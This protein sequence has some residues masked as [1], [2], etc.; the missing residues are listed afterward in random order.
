MTE[1]FVNILKPEWY[2]MSREERKRQRGE[3]ETEK[4]PKEEPKEKRIKTEH[5]GTKSASSSR[6]TSSS[7]SSAESLGGVASPTLCGPGSDDGTATTDVTN[8]KKKIVGIGL[9]RYQTSKAIVFH[10]VSTNS[11]SFH[12][13]KTKAR[14]ALSSGVF[15][16]QG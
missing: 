4:E 10:G 5:G 14:T 2:N 9:H 15:E 11:S 16:A 12:R 6:P 1:H 3:K 8:P 7:A 13:R